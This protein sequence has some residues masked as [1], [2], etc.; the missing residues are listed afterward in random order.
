[1]RI[2]H[3]ERYRIIKIRPP[4]PDV[5]LLLHL[6][7]NGQA[8]RFSCVWQVL[9]V[10]QGWDFKWGL[11]MKKIQG[12]LKSGHHDLMLTYFCTYF[13]MVILNVKL[14]G[15]ALFDKF[16]KWH[17]VETSKEDLSWR[18]I[19]CIKSRS[20][21]PYIDLFLHFFSNGNTLNV[22]LLGLAMFDK[23]YMCHKVET[24]NEDWSWRKIQN[25]LKLG[26]HDLTLTYF[27]TCFQM[28]KLS[29]LAVFD[30]FYMCHK[31]GTSNEDWSWRKIQ[32]LLKSGHH[33]LM[34]TYFCTYFKWS[35]LMLS[36]QV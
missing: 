12:L 14:S 33:D 35:Y 19:Q 34:L 21:W 7:S 29:G 20:P 22:K 9:H 26:H 28:V 31:V 13:Q 11:I 6:F 16:Y 4:W 1:M 32:G 2:D 17:K 3:E 18:V 30:K 10:S 27:C 25:L 23:F 24:S 5:D 15:L 36:F 8:L